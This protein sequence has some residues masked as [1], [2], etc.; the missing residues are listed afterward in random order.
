MPDISHALKWGI[1]NDKI[2]NFELWFGGR[3][4][5]YGSVCQLIFHEKNLNNNLLI[6][7]YLEVY[8]WSKADYTE[9]SH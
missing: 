1:L 3:P 5:D 6:Q 2:I 7:H 8:T 4:F 9:R